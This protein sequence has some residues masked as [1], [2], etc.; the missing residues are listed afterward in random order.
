MK[1]KV[2]LILPFYNEEKSALNTLDLIKNQTVAPNE[3][4]F[5]NSNSSDASKQIITDYIKNNKLKNW[6][7]FDTKL[8]TPS[9][10]KNFGIR[11][12]NNQWCA[13]MD[14]D[15]TFSKRWIEDQINFIKTKKNILISFGTLRLY[16]KNHF[17]KMV[18]SQTYGLNSNK[19]AIPSSFIK[20][21]YFFQY[22]YFLPY[23]STY[24]KIFILNSFKNNED[25]LGINNKIKIKYLN[26]N[27]ADNIKTLFLKIFNY[28]LQSFLIKNYFIPHL[29]LGI[30]FSIIFL[31]SYDIN[32]II[33]I[34]SI[35][36]LLRGFIIPYFKNKNFF[37][38]FKY[39]EI[40]YLF[41]VGILIDMFKCIGFISS[42][43][44]KIF[45]IK[46][47]LDKLY[48]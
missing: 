15:L 43:I 29:Y 3:V 5:V 36:L 4:I 34:F 48:K 26:I 30:F 18:I 20:K 21:D 13:F 35:L 46:I 14:F 9:E 37:N 25:H 32:F 24:D 19:P 2:S 16:P 45:K 23:R 12:S 44:L 11:K 47:R 17:D 27:Y 41:F 40:P 7:N 39:Y 22:G 10:A 28:S 31:L 6:I 33:V 8:E 42:F 1:L 38:E